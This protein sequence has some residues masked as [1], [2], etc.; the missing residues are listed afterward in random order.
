M[1]IFYY[2][3]RE[4]FVKSVLSNNILTLTCVHLETEIIYLGAWYLRDIPGFN[5]NTP[6]NLELNKDILELSNSNSRLRLYRA[7]HDISLIQEA[8][9]TALKYKIEKLTPWTFTRK[10]YFDNSIMISSRDWIEIDHYTTDFSI[11]CDFKFLQ[12]Y[13]H[14]PYCGNE[15]LLIASERCRS[16][17]R[18]VIDGHDICNSVFYSDDAHEPV[19]NITLSGLVENVSSGNH[20]IRLFGCVDNHTF[21]VPFYN[22]QS[23]EFT[24]KPDYFANLYMIGYQK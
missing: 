2:P 9:I 1:E 6:L 18:L 15:G 17:L 24:M 4:L 19:D 3:S 11:P 20:T 12:V 13:L 5:F 21:N 16:R 7:T 8:Q 14:I 10:Y 22:D 23:I